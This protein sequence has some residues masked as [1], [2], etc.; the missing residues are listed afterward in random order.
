MIVAVLARAAVKEVGAP[1][2]R[3]DSNRGPFGRGS[4]ANLSTF[5]HD[6]QL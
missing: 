2:G 3:R 4:R 1:G 6:W 5:Q